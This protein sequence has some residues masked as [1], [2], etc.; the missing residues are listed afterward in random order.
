MFPAGCVVA[1]GAF[2]GVHRG[3][4]ALLGR[5]RALAREHDYTAV[6]LSFEPLPREYFARGEPPAR[7]TPVRM[8]IELLRDTGM[9]A[10][11]LLRF[12]DALAAMSAEDFVER[13]LVRGLAARMVCIG[14][15]FRFGRG[16]AGDIALLNELGA[17]FDY[18]VDVAPELIGADGRRIGATRVREALAAGAFLSAEAGLGRP[19]AIAGRVVRGNRLGSKLG[20]PTANIPVR[21]RPAVHGIFAVRVHGGDELRAWPAVASLGS[22]PTVGGGP[23]VLEAHLFDFDRDLYGRRLQVE[24]VGKLREE[25]RFDSLEAMVEQMHEDARRA[26]AALAVAPANAA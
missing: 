26:R 5:A 14:P 11:G 23:N 20:F 18:T 19:Y 1:I 7:L 2:D 9:D 15:D 21:W 12:N 17:K 4:Q 13:V 22:R 10:V 16:R 3:H 24:F 6:A 25:L 8:K